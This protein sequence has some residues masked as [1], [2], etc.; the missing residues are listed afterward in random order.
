MRLVDGYENS[1][2]K[3]AT[4]EEALW[5]KKV[6]CAAANGEEQKSCGRNHEDDDVGPEKVVGSPRIRLL[7]VWEK[8][9]RHL[10]L[11]TYS[12]NRRRVMK[13]QKNYGKSIL[14]YMIATYCVYILCILL[15][16]Y[17]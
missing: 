1:H 7:H 4:V 13:D 10:K 3:G 16:N 8:S 2:D 15:T 5:Q 9:V 6:L 17:I 14:K 11:C 12:I